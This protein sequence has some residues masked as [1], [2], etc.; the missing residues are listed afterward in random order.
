MN[1]KEAADRSGLP[2]KTIR[3]YE[4]IG[5]IHPS[6]AANGYRDF[7]ERETAKLVFLARA[8]S[9]GFSIP[10]CRALLSLYE[11]RDRASADVKRL[12]GERLA[13]I[14][15]KIAELQSLRA[16]LEDLVERC[17]GD[18]RPDC[19]ILTD[20]AGAFTPLDAP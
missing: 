18:A 7:S 19:P 5:L 20:L 9:L 14:A 15:R 11:D 3:Y 2:A 8:R 10:D 4:E 6:R 13:E 16:V 12:A 1:I 17:Q